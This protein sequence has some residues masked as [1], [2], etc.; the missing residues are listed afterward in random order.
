MDERTGGFRRHGVFELYRNIV[1][2]GRYDGIRMQDLRP[3]ICQLRSFVEREFGYR[4]GFVH[5]PR[6]VVVHAV[7]IG[8]DLNQFSPGCCPDQRSGVIAS[9]ALEVVDPAQVIGAD[10]PLGHEQLVFRILTEHFSQAFADTAQVRFA[11]F[12]D[13]HEFQGRK[14]HIVDPG[15]GQVIAEHPGRHQLALGQNLP[16]I[17]L[18]VWHIQLVLNKAEA[19]SRFAQGLVSPVG[20]AV[21]LFYKAFVVLAKELDFAVRTGPVAAFDQ[22]ANFYQGIGRA[23]QCGKHCDFSALVGA[24]KPCHALHSLRGTH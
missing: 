11:V 14:E 2:A 1:V 23:R 6:I 22:F 18:R 24:E 10:I 16:C 4:E 17:V 3:E 8:P 5:H 21:Q 13:K 12:V 20:I 7:D 19:F 15:F 9:A